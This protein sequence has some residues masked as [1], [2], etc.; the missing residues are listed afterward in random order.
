[1]RGSIFFGLAL[2]ISLAVVPRGARACGRGG[3]YNYSGLVTIALVA[4]SVDAGLTFWDGGSALASHHPSAGYG[5]LELIVAVPQLVLGAAATSH[6]AGGSSAFNWYTVW[7]GLMTAH[8]V[9]T[10]ATAPS[11]DTPS[12]TWIR[13]R[14]SA[15]DQDKK[16]GALLSVGPTYVPLGERAHPAV[17]LLGRFTQGHVGRPHTVAVLEAA[18]ARIIPSEDGPG[19]REAKVGRFIE[20]QLAGDLRELRPAFEQVARLL[21]L[22]AGRAYGKPFVAL[23]AAEQDVGLELL[24][25]GQIPARGLPQEAMFRALHT[26]ALEGFLSD[27]VHGGNDGQVG[28]RFVSFPEPHLRKP[29]GHHGR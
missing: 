8:G 16:P 25:H 28:W 15:P 26:L 11:D 22:W 24:A 3:G 13:D 29:G 17:G 10:I 21:D 19:A 1:M 2:A 12:K 7:M 27:P 4:L 23:A 6:N 5:V 14:L 9:W 18:A 20:R